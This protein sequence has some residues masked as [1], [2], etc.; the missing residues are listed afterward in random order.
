[1]L[2]DGTRNVPVV[3]N[4]VDTT[5][6]SLIDIDCVDLDPFD[7]KFGNPA[8]ELCCIDSSSRLSDM[9][10]PSEEMSLSTILPGGILPALSS[11]E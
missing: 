7:S 2:V 11:D 3:F 6:G 10:R 8:G 5:G 1:M 4:W 9:T